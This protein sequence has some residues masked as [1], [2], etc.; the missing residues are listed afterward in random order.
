MSNIVDWATGQPLAANSLD[1]TR[2]TSAINARLARRIQEATPARLLGYLASVLPFRI[3]I[4]R[5]GSCLSARNGNASVPRSYWLALTAISKIFGEL[6]LRPAQ[7]GNVGNACVDSRR[8][9]EVGC[10]AVQ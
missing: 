4:S 9:W 10:P 8:S 6:G 7:R 1:S 5:S 3:P 2:K